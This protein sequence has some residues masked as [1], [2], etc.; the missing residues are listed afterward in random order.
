MAV[1]WGVL[2]SKSFE[3]EARPQALLDGVRDFNS[4]HYFEAHEHWEDAL[5]ELPDHQWDLF[6]GLIQIAVGYHK[7]GQNLLG[8]AAGMLEKGLEKMKEISPEGLPVEIE[9][10]RKRVA[11]DIESLRSEKFDFASWKQS[12]PRLRIPRERR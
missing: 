8:G 4:G 5:E 7:L 11:S 3:M 1:G 2:F 9:P 12:P 10:L 6:I